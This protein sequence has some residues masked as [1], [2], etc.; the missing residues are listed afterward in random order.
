MTNTFYFEDEMDNF[1]DE[2][3]E[4]DYDPMEG[5]LTEITNPNITLETI[6]N[7]QTYLANKPTQK[8]ILEK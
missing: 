2:H 3:D 7:R 1:F 4:K 8:N 6:T 5:V